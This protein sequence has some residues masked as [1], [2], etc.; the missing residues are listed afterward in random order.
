MRRAGAAKIVALVPAICGGE[1]AG[2][3]AT[4]FKWRLIWPA[5]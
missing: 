1:I 5:A 2:I 3:S 4:I